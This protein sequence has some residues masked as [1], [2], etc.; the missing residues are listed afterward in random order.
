MALKYIKN[1]ISRLSK[2]YP[3]LDF[4]FQNTPSGNPVSEPA[5]WMDG[6]EPIDCVSPKMTEN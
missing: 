6:F 1:S 3:N 5:E 2:I 4:W